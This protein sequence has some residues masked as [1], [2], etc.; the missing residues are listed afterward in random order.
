MRHV[1]SCVQWFVLVY[2]VS[3]DGAVLGL[4]LRFQRIVRY[5]QS[6]HHNEAL[7]ERR[8]EEEGQERSR[9]GE[10]DKRS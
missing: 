4:A 6:T 9:G 2:C 5:L 8:N 3:L 7:W 1:H 10:N